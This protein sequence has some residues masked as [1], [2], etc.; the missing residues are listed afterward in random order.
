MTTSSSVIYPFSSPT[1][2]GP[3][4][5]ICPCVDL[6]LGRPGQ[7]FCGKFLGHVR[8]PWELMGSPKLPPVAWGI[9]PRVHPVVFEAAHRAA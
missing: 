7:G 2:P 5:S 4:W 9:H 6:R 3:G 1:P 8:A